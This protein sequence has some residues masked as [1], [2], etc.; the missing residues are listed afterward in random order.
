LIFLTVIVSVLYIRR[1]TP[2]WITNARG[3]QRGGTK[4]L[5][6]KVSKEREKDRSSDS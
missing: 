2:K 6:A 3:L 5:N 4:T 1:L